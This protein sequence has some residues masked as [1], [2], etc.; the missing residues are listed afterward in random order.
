MICYSSVCLNLV[1][2]SLL[3]YFGSDHKLDSSEGLGTRQNGVPRR[4]LFG[5]HDQLLFTLEMGH[6]GCIM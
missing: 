4:P 6:S 5:V 2:R 3:L 1:P